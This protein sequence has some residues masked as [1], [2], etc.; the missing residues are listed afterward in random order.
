MIYFLFVAAALIT[1]VTA[2][3]LSTYADVIG[4]RTKLGGMMAGVLLLAGATS[5]PEVTTSITAVLVDN[6]DIAVSN[7]FGSNLFNLFI[8]AAVD[9]FYRKRRILQAADTSHLST[10]VLGFFMT[11]CMAVV[12]LFP[13]GWSIFGI[14]LEMIL[15][16]GLYIAG[17]VFISR[18]GTHLTPL[19]ADEPEPQ[20][21]AI[22]LRHAK[23]GFA[24]AAAI[25][26]AAGSA[27]SVTGDMIAQA[28]GISSS[29]VGAFLIAGATSLPELVTVI[30]SVQL[31]NHSMAIG[32]ILGSNVF[33]MLILFIID[34]VYRGGPVLSVVSPA[35]LAAAVGVLILNALVIAAVMIVNRKKPAAMY[36]L[37]SALV[38]LVYFLSS[39]AIFS[40]S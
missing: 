9:L 32:N 24:V 27:L 21:N 29:F 18:S 38:I 4:E 39:Y 3:K 2:V 37:P 14:G 11:A 23:R 30:V 8:L 19:S 1:V 34:A 25:I 40:F 5:L 15:L 12:I 26:L 35:V 31:A 22:S 20:H 13:P 10:A 6:P 36:S 33:N 17:M 16:V 7:V 28:T